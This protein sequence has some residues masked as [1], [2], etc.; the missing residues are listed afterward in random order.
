MDIFFTNSFTSQKERFVPYSASNVK[1]YVCGPTVYDRIHM[2][3][4]RSIFTFDILYKLLKEFY[5]V[6]YVRNITDID[7]KIITTSIKHSK[8]IKTFTT[9]MIKNFHEDTRDLRCEP[10]CFEPKATDNVDVIIEMISTL[11]AKEHAYVVKDHVYFSVDSF[12]NYGNLSNKNLSELKPGIRVAKVLD[13][14]SPLDFV[15]WKPTKTNETLYFNSP[16]GRGRPGWHI[17]CSAMSKRFLGNQ[18]D[19]HGGGIDLLFPHHENERAQSQCESQ[20]NKFV[21]YW[22]HNG[23]VTIEGSK[24]SKSLSNFTTLRDLLDRGVSPAV[25]RYFFLTTHYRKPL[26]FN[27]KAIDT[28]QKNIDKINSF[29]NSHESK[30][31]SSLPQEFLHYLAD[32][33]NTPKVLAY[34]H[35]LMLTK[36]TGHQ[37]RLRDCCKFLGLLETKQSI[38]DNIKILAQTRQKYKEQKNWIQSD[39]IRR[40]IER[41]GYKISD[42]GNNYTITKNN[43][44]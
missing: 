16:W 43:K 3:N 19:I 34:L 29:C 7:D 22:I 18:I 6:T 20:D 42:Q 17:E 1:I 41:K 38:S 11:L 33:L 32:D 44:L 15:L 13:K 12:K 8:D 35:Q 28:A 23:L 26:D 25:I 21:K 39:I 4:A 31:S 10:P 24:M 37:D 5:T 30:E 14:R 9:E 36:D 27:Y 2:G 40:E